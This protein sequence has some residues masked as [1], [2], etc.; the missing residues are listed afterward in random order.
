MSIKNRLIML[1]N[2]LFDIISYS[3]YI[4]IFHVI[5]SL[6]DCNILPPGAGS[7]LNLCTAQCMRLSTGETQ[8][9]YETRKT[10]ALICGYKSCQSST[11]LTDSI[12]NLLVLCY[13]SFDIILAQKQY[14]CMYY[15]FRSIVAIIRYIGPSQSPF[16]PSA[17]P[18][19]TGQDTKIVSTD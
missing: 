15:I 12:N 11:N 4:E 7:V 6:K 5:I 8:V 10:Y 13:Y 17:L 2:D 3:R 1:I 9:M 19:Y 16:F 18:P 14:V